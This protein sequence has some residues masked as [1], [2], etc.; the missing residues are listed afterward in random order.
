MKRR[1]RS[2]ERVTKAI[3]SGR[4][5][6]V[7]ADASK[8]AIYSRD[9]GVFYDPAWQDDVVIGLEAKSE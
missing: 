8:P 2:H 9:D 7:A 4:K 6:A 1:R 3:L 5:E